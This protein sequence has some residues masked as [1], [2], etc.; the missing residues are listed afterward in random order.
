MISEEELFKVW[1]LSRND[2]Y[3]PPL[4]RPVIASNVKGITILQTKKWASFIEMKE[5]QV[6]FNPSC[7]DVFSNWRNGGRNIFG[8]EIIHYVYC[9][10]DEKTASTLVMSAAKAVEKHLKKPSINVDAVAATCCNF[11]NDYVDDSERIR[12]GFGDLVISQTREIVDG[13]K[14][15]NANSVVWKTFLR[16][17]ELLWD[18]DL[19]LNL[20]DEE[21]EDY[22]S[23]IELLLKRDWDIKEKWPRQVY[24]ITEIF[25]PLFL[26]EKKLKG[27]EIPSELTEQMH[28]D[29]TVIKYKEKGKGGGDLEEVVKETDSYGKLQKKIDKFKEIV[30]IL[31]GGGKGREKGKK[32]GTAEEA[33]PAIPWDEVI[34]HEDLIKLW[35][36]E[37]DKI[38]FRVIPF[39][40]KT[41]TPMIPL[42][43]VP[44]YPSRDELSKLDILKTK[45]TYP[46]PIL[47]TTTKKW[48]YQGIPTGPKEK[49]IYPNYLP[50]LDTSGSMGDR[51]NAKYTD[52]AGRIRSKMIYGAKYYFAAYVA[53]LTSHYVLLKGEGA[54]V[55]P[56]NFS[57]KGLYNDWTSN[58][59]LVMKFWATEQAGG[60]ELPGDVLLKLN[61]SSNR[62]VLNVLITDA[63]IFNF[64][65]TYPYLEKIMRRKGSQMALFKVGSIEENEVVEKLKKIK[66]EIYAVN[67]LNDLNRVVL[68][69][70]RYTYDYAIAG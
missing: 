54:K 34:F 17:Y 37:K 38:D 8:H 4:S 33:G 19:H 45:Q 42:T 27:N 61:E 55:A 16:G 67:S 47:G 60:T 52:P 21:L 59:D 31:R 23:E 11:H 30:K 25:L 20:K 5:Y 29:P 22:A 56:V 1:D 43:P 68:G 70:V 50:A 3:N 41:E 12:R 18:I 49:Q 40:E 7:L 36:L 58:L 15:R 24:R 14:Q 65:K 57:N 63:E 44:W 46:K 48:E 2:F 62:P 66:C 26:E 69:R 64:D 39:K 10:Y 51:L 32:E 13:L 53:F 6:Y 35:Y 28:G 9:P